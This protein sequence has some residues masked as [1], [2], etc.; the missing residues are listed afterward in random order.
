MPSIQSACSSAVPTAAA[1]DY[2]SFC[3]C[4]YNYLPLHHQTVVAVAVAGATDSLWLDLVEYIHQSCYRNAGPF[5]LTAE[6]G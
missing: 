1:I 2:C 6:L 3:C 5:F 4:C